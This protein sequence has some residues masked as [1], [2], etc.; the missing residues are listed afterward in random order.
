MLFT[1]IFAALHFDGQTVLNYISAIGLG[2][3]LTSIILIGRKVFEFG[4]I[5]Q[6]LDAVEK[7][8]KDVKKEVRSGNRDLAR[9]IDE[10]M[11][12][13]VHHGPAK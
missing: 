10:L 8:I 4:K 3:L 12:A 13:I 7:D 5:M 11:L 6:R 2:T 1:E 9:R